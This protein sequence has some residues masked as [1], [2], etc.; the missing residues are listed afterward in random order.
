MG[1]RE[2]GE[3]A[4]PPS[5]Y[6]SK[7]R[8]GIAPRPLYESHFDLLTQTRELTAVL[9]GDGFEAPSLSFGLRQ[10]RR[11]AVRRVRHGVSEVVLGGTLKSVNS[12]VHVYASSRMYTHRLGCTRIVSPWRCTRARPADEPFPW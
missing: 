8:E 7:G 1:E 3:G 6:S 10:P 9:A 5:K 12:T 11:A 4:N 2:E